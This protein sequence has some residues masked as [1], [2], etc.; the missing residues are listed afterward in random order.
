VQ[1]RAEA[2]L[3]FGGLLSNTMV[4][5][6]NI[7][8]IAATVFALTLSSAS[9][10]MAVECAS[11]SQ[12]KASVGQLTSDIDWFLSIVEE[13]PAGVAQQFKAVKITDQ[14]AFR[15]AISHPLWGAN[16]IRNEASNIKGSLA[17][18]LTQTPDWRIKRAIEALG[19][20]GSLINELSQYADNNPGR[21]IV[22]IQQWSYNYTVL[23]A[24]LE[25][26]AL[27]LV[28]NRQ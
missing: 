6:L 9:D 5:A 13:V 22:D 16:K 8:R 12:R 4:T 20:G 28:D 2:V 7:S 27:C 23:A 26:F 15:N 18:T 1:T 14:R 21:R 17:F 25:A 24:Q 11:E 19:S 3:N 10:A